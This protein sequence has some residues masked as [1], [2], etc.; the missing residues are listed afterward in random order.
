MKKTIFAAAFMSA[1]LLGFSGAASANDEFVAGC[2]ANSQDAADQGA[3]PEQIEG[4]CICLGA[5]IG[6]NAAAIASLQE[7]AGDPSKI[8]P[9]AM[10]AIQ[11]CS[12]Q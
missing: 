7:A 10:A 4:F 1:A 9:E 2:V 5:A 11:S 6:D 12:P 3:T 8:S